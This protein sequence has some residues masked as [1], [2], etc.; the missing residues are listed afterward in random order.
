M[1][2]E[3]TTGFSAQSRAMGR[4]DSCSRHDPLV[5][6]AKYFLIILSGL[7]FLAGNG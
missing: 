1:G 2:D 5:D 6:R 3:P 4:D 7:S